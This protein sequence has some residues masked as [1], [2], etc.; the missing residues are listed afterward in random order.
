M[1]KNTLLIIFLVSILFLY[2]CS[3]PQPT[4]APSPTPLPGP[5]PIPTPTPDPTPRPNPGPEPTPISPK[6]IEASD[7]KADAIDKSF[8]ASNSEFAFDVFRE[9]IEEDK[10]QN[11]FISPFSISTALTMTY[12]GAEGTTKDAME[13]TLKLGSSMENTN[14]EYKNLIESLDKVD[15]KI[16][17]TVSNSIWVNK[18]FEPSLKQDFKDRLKG[19]YN[20]DIFAR[21]FTDSKSAD[22]INNWIGNSTNDM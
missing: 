14:K 11:I 19:N 6:D 7:E 21:D 12:N 1:F 4:P 15:S 16:K 17:L 9:L 22:E 8:T 18:S 10:D 5:E 20:S 2:G 13:K 3:P